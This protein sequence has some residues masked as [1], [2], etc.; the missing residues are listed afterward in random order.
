MI[1]F[2][3]GSFIPAKRLNYVL[4]NTKNNFPYAANLLQNY[5]IEGFASC[6]SE[7]ISFTRFGIGSFPKNSK[8][9]WLPSETI[10]SDE[11]SITYCSSQINIGLLKLLS[12]LHCLKRQ[13]MSELRK[14]KT[15]NCYV[16]FYSLNDNFIKLAPILKKRFPNVKVAVTINDLPKFTMLSKNGPIFSLI[17]KRRQELSVKT[18][19]VTD[20]F[21]PVSNTVSRFLKLPTSKTLVIDGM[22]SCQSG[23]SLD[24]RVP[25]RIGYCG[26]LL[27]SY[28]ILDFL[29]E[30]VSSSLPYEVIVCGDGELSEEI[31]KMSGEDH[32]IIFLGLLSHDDLK[33]ELNT[34]SCFISPV[35]PQNPFTDYSFP[36]K[37]LDYLSV[38]RPVVSFW[39]GGYSEEYRDVLFIPKNQTY[40]S[41]LE[42]VQ[43]LLSLPDEEYFDICKKS[44]AFVF[45][46]KT[47]HMQCERILRLL[48]K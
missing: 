5:Y 48:K 1:I 36:I 21:F 16:F 31:K 34:C 24:R 44:Q 17:K 3:V 37:V 13:I 9:F 4:R 43:D 29:K 25:N 19:L 15:E 39:L 2:F 35:H 26:A 40:G 41:F 6:Q 45:N 33:A 7:L 10:K 14:H 42:R 27:R 11:K 8:I 20:Y 22:S 32:R 46:N 28:G 38:G 23:L 18:L 47:P 12:P 30:F